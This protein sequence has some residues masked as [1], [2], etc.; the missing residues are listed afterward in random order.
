[1]ETLALPV[2]VALVVVE[3]LG[4]AALVEQVATTHFLAGHL[5]QVG[6][7]EAEVVAAVGMQTQTTLTPER[8]LIRA[9]EAEEALA[10]WA[11][12]VT[13]QVGILGLAVVLSAE[14]EEAPAEAL[15]GLEKTVQEVEEHMVEEVAGL[16]IAPC[17][18]TE[19]LATALSVLSASSGVLVAPI[20]RT[21]QTSN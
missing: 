7:V 8:L 21:P 20:R 4:I 18:V 13:E 14:V 1:V 12:A 11:P 10:F 17:T 9:E 2:L 3:P 5:E 19:L 16:G 6:L 15:A